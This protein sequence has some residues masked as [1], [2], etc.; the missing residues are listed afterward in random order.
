MKLKLIRLANIF[1]FSFHQSFIILFAAIA[2][3]IVGSKFRW[4]FIFSGILILLIYSVLFPI[5][6]YPKYIEFFDNRICY[7]SPENLPRKRGKGFMSAKVSYQVTNITRC[8]L[9][10]N[11]IERLFGFA[12][13]VFSG[14][15]TFDA[16]KYTNRFPTK[17][18]HCVYG[19]RYNKYKDDIALYCKQNNIKQ[20][21]DQAKL[22]PQ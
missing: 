22:T 17:E 6:N 18:V 7:V 15:T 8:T 10:Q 14:K 4:D 1:N 19:I 5:L 13:I 21:Q 16:G 12:H 3:G 2:V 9:E 11:K 20:K